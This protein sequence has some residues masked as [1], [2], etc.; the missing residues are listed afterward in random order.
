MD[1]DYER[2]FR[3]PVIYHTGII[4][5]MSNDKILKTIEALK[6][7]SNP[8]QEKLELSYGAFEDIIVDL[9]TSEEYRE[10]EDPLL[11]KR[12]IE[13]LKD[14]FKH[15]FEAYLLQRSISM[16]SDNIDTLRDRFYKDME[17]RRGITPP[18]FISQAYPPITSLVRL[19]RN[20]HHE[21][22][23]TVDHVTGKRGFGNVYTLCSTLTLA[24]YAYI[25]ILETWEETERTNPG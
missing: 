17:H 16:T 21:A 19:V 15:L 7:L 3:Y 18:K 13:E 22:L 24:I 11:F 12:S 2:P 8:C 4:W 1:P 14:V 9:T 10:E 25:E 5:N 20:C 23:G 6:H